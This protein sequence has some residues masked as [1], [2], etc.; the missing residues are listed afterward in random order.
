MTKTMGELIKA[1][2][3]L[4]VLFNSPVKDWK[5]K[6]ALS[7]MSKAIT[8]KNEEY[9]EAHKTISEKYQ[10]LAKEN[11][12]DTLH[13]AQMLSYE[14]EIQEPLEIEVELDD[15][16]LNAEQLQEFEGLSANN[17]LHLEDLEMAKL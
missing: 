15:L 11:K 12:D 1:Q 4:R 5:L 2:D 6:L 3:A 8:E 17:I 16:V 13:P 7:K 10:A 9:S 14:K